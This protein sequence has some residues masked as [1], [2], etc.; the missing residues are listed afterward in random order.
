M[1]LF[2][3]GTPIGN[4]SDMTNRAIE[5]LRTSDLILCE[6]IER[7]RKILEKFEIKWKRMITFREENKK[8][9]TPEIIQY[10]K[11]KKNISLLSDAGMPSIS[12]PGAY[13]IDEAL[14]SGIELHCVPGPTA[15]ASALSI[16]GLTAKEAIFLGFLPR[17]K[18]EITEIIDFYSTRDV[19]LIF[20]ESPQR[21]LETLK[22]INEIDESSTIFIARELTKQYEELIRGTP[23]KIINILSGREIRGEITVVMK[24]SLKEK[25]TAY[26]DRLIEI[27]KME[28]IK[29]KTISK[30]IS[31]YYNIPARSIYNEIIKEED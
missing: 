4:L 10:L 8:R 12:D 23:E 2:I 28:G 14:E 3:V 5:T 31:K 17:H 27:L 19:V 24:P 20:Y 22:V 18:S 26:D 11:D 13:L 9:I 7:V 16:S 1:P 30:V 6:S 25:K 29:T 15:F 21:I